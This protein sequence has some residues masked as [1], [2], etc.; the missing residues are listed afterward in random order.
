MPYKRINSLAAL[1]GENLHTHFALLK[2]C[3]YTFSR[4]AGC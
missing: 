3:A 1:A 2:D 4:Y